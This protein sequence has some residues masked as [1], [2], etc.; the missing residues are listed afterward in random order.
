MAK[1]S[2]GIFHRNAKTGRL[3][4]ADYAKRNPD[5]TVAVRVGAGSGG[6]SHSAKGRRFVVGRYMRVNPRTTVTK[7]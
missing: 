4:T 3:V 6:G 1:K 2:G 5:I 7:K